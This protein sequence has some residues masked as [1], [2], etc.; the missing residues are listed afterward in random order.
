MSLTKQKRDEI[1]QFILWNVSQHPNDIVRFAQKKYKVS[2]T[3]ILNYISELGHENLIEI[4][5]ST[6]DREY[7]LKPLAQFSKAYQIADGLAE[8][9]I[10]RN[11]IVPLM[12]DIKENVNAICHYG[13]TEIFN[14]AIDHSEGTTIAVTATL[15]FDRILLCIDDNGIG[16]FNKIQKEY[17]LD[18]PLHAILELSKGKL[19]TDPETHTGEGIFFTSRMFDTFIISSG[20]YYFTTSGIDVMF[21]SERDV[22]GTEVYMQISRRANR[23]TAGVFSQFTSDSGTFGFDK[24]IVPVKLARYGNENLISRSQAKRLMSR[25]D[26]FRTVVL[27]FDNVTTIGRAFADEVFRVFSKSHPNIKVLAI[28]DSKEIRRLIDDIQNSSER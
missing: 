12:L 19:T 8:D 5:G 7:A 28:N 6:R 14:N 24:T 4:K 18:D 26:K 27:D 15:W 20:K 2:K 9:K 16:I 21:E 3:T 25:L 13:F 10:W 23:T 11:D 17:E 22:L 1:K